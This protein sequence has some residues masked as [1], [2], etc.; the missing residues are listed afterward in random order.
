MVTGRVG[1]LARKKQIRQLLNHMEH[2]YMD[3]IFDST[4]F[5][6]SKFKRVQVQAVKCDCLVFHL[7]PLTVLCWS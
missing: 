5:K 7:T 1:T 3:D 2:G 4:P 6:K